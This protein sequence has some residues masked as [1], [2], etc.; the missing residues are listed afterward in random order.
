[1]PV[2]TGSVPVHSYID[3]PRLTVDMLLKDPGKIPALVFSMSDQMFLA[4]ALLRQAGPVGGGAI[5][6]FSSTPFYSDSNAATRAEFAEVPVA[7]GSYGAPNV[8]Y[9]SER[10]LAILV[11]DEMRRRMN[12]DPVTVQ[13]QQVRNT[14]VQSWDQT[15]VNLVTSN[16]SNVVAGSQWGAA[17]TGSAIRAD[18]VAAM[19]LIATAKAPG[20]N[21]SFGFKADTMVVGQGQ[22]FNLVRQDDFNKPF[23]GNIASE[24]LQ[25]TGKLPNK[26]MGLD[27]V[28]SR[29][30][31]DDQVL[32][33]ERKRCGFIA[34]E[35]PLQTSAMYRDE[36][37]KTFR[38][39]VQRASAMGLDQ[40][41]SMAVINVTPG[42]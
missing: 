26:I 34:D 39:D 5:E 30:L 20:Q 35:L 40:P 25:Y 22:Q 17:T 15:F 8:A 23:V 29:V 33:M 31:S 24:N 32:L 38:C 16:T 7:Q 42:P 19:K 14:L 6:Y 28:V 10:A 21:T 13:L 1:M 37:R 4:D 9:V 36:P 12:I 2:Q 18:I 41:L 27:V 3:G 11:S